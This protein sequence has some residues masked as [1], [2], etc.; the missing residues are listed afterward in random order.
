LIPLDIVRK[1][2]PFQDLKILTQL[3]SIFKRKKFDLV[4]SIMPKTGLLAM[5]AGR[6]TGVPC[7][8]HTFTGQVW[9]NKSG[10]QRQALKMFDR[11]IVAMATQILVDSPSQRDFLRHE[12]ILPPG[13][14]R[15]I[16]NGSI[17]GINTQKFH[18]DPS[19]RKI[20]REKLKLS[21]TDIV[22]LFLGR[23]N[24]DKGMIDLAKAFS[25]ISPKRP[26]AV[27]LLVGAE[28]DVTFAQIEEICSACRHRLRRVEFTPNPEKYVAASDIFCL[29]SYRE[30]FGQTIIEAAASEIPT[31]AS[32]IYGVTDAVEEGVTGLLFPPGNLQ[33]L[34]EALLKLIDDG[35][36]RKKMGLAARKRAI[37]LFSSSIITNE[38]VELYASSMKNS[39]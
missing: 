35:N 25:A 36:L 15:V 38:L 4:H 7:R 32:R 12:R 8:I 3:I 9:A 20:V 18:P 27:L 28:E 16:A 30:G 24:R 22:L 19:A 11:M 26:E 17:C 2:S 5:I 33:F 31:A 1:A 6:L 14:G 13:T 21:E 29:P 39:G 37:E 34:E 23:L 10:L